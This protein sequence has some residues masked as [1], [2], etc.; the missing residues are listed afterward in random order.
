M[1]QLLHVFYRFNRG[2]HG[3]AV[4]SVL[5]GSL[6]LFGALLASAV[7]EPLRVTVAAVAIAAVLVILNLGIVFLNLLRAKLNDTHY[8]ISLEAGL[9][10]AGY[11]LVDFF[12]DGAAANPSLQLLHL[13]ILRFCR[14]QRVLELGSGQTT[15]L[16]SCYARE[17]SSA[18]V[19][20]LEQNESWVQ[21]LKEHVVHDYR[22]APLQPT[23]F[24]CSGSKLRLTT[25]WYQD[26]PELR[27][28]HFDYVLVDGP[29]PGTPGTSHNDYSR[30]GILQYLPAIL[31]PSFVVVF[32]DAERYGEIMT[33]RALEDILKACR[34][35]Y[36][37]FAVHGIKTQVVF[38]SRDHS[39]LRS[40]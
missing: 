13:K 29:D 17:N 33:M 34:V 15:K 24:I 20:S 8:A 5:I 39:Y 4:I 35:Q 25:M 37:H 18:Y 3:N 36:V 1:H 6:L 9:R 31:S 7:Y 10:R 23:Q 11:D 38:C 40:V 2:P 26:L 27:E 12:A 14:P 32:D 28:G 22:H 21:R 16:L 30:S 19:L